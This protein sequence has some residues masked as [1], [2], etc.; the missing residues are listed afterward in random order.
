MAEGLGELLPGFMVFL[1]VLLVGFWC[2]ADSGQ[3]S[4]LLVADAGRLTLHQPFHDLPVF[5][6]VG[7]LPFL[8]NKQLKR[9]GERL[10]LRLLSGGKETRPPA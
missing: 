6:A 2:F 1:V 9:M 3:F 5:G 8:K 10:D 7:D 4:A